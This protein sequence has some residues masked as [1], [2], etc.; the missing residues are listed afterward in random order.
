MS[1]KPN[2]EEQADRQR[3]EAERRQRE[4]EAQAELERQVHLAA[5]SERDA[6]ARSELDKELEPLSAS[7]KFTVR[8]HAYIIASGRQHSSPHDKQQRMDDECLRLARYVT[9][10]KA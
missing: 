10:G 5:I 1:T 9:T 7:Q 3:A 4:R 8:L 2:A 6:E